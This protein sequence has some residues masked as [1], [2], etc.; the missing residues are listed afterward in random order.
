A[1][2][3]EKFSLSSGSTLATHRPRLSSECIEARLIRQRPAHPNGRLRYQAVSARTSR[4]GEPLRLMMDRTLGP[5]LQKRT[6]HC[7][8][9]TVGDD[10]FNPSS[11]KWD[12]DGRAFRS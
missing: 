1:C 7:Q 5:S 4:P 12:L 6:P 2:G 9:T 8:G 3:P 11:M 10:V